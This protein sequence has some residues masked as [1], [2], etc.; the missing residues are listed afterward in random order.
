[1]RTAHHTIRTPPRAPAAATNHDV[2]CASLDRASTTKPL[3]PGPRREEPRLDTAAYAIRSHLHL[4]LRTAL[5]TLQRTGPDQSRSS[6]RAFFLHT[7]A[8]MFHARGGMRGRGRG[9]VLEAYLR[10][11]GLLVF[12][13]RPRPRPRAP[14]HWPRSEAVHAHDNAC[15]HRSQSQEPCL[16]RRRV[17][18]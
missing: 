10:A 9:E 11:L 14:R 13:P 5:R 12:V 1:M 6:P 3:A 8:L 18:F 16:H 17:L 4:A 7:H 15:P 2:S